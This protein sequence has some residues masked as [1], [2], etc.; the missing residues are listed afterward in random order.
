MDNMCGGGTLQSD[1]K[2]SVS[3]DNLLCIGKGT[4]FVVMSR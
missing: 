2:S 3:T 1:E 4:D